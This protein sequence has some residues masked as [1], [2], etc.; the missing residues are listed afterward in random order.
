MQKQAD[1]AERHRSLKHFKG[2]KGRSVVSNIPHFNM[3]TGF[4]PDY[5]H[6]ILLGVMLMLI[7]LWCSTSNHREDYYLSKTFR[8]EID[9]MLAS[10]LPPDTLTRKPR[11]LIYLS[12]WKASELRSF[13]LFLGP[14]LLRNKLCKEYYDHFLLLVRA[15]H[16][17]LQNE[18]DEEELKLAETLLHIFASDVERPYGRN[19]CL[20]NVHQLLHMVK[21]VRRWGPLWAWSTFSAEDGNGELLKIKHGSRN[22]DVEICNT[23]KLIHAY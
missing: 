16:I 15:V 12:F 13:L 19:R 9:A 11:K 17:L 8:D 10:I 23:I 22:I 4:V 21:F 7:S 14:V 6:A 2:M 18:I 5:L 20:Y 1:I 3:G